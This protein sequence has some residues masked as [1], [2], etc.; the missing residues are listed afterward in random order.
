MSF[1]FTAI[2]GN[3]YAIKLMSRKSLTILDANTFAFKIFVFVALGQHR[4]P[5]FSR[6]AI[7]RQLGVFSSACTFHKSDFGYLILNWI[8]ELYIFD[9]CSRQK[10]W[11]CFELIDFRQRRFRHVLCAHIGSV[12]IWM[13]KGKSDASLSTYI[14]R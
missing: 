10:S 13:S 4:K 2:N 5:T 8:S 1:L 12:I 14:S 7:T 9:A 6:L 3:A 11:T